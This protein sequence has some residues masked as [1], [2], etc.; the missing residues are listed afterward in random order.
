MK[1]LA[2]LEPRGNAL[3]GAEGAEGAAA[4]GGAT[5]GGATNDARRSMDEARESIVDSREANLSLKVSMST[6]ERAISLCSSSKRPAGNI[7]KSER[8]K[9]RSP[10]EKEAI[11]GD[12]SATEKQVKMAK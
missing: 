8:E 12:E 3:G 4:T 2:E 1:G 5:T 9:V 7:G 6:A 11:A 10:I